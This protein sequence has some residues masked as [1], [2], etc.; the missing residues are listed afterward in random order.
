MHLNFKPFAKIGKEALTRA[1][2]SR[3]EAVEKREVLYNKN[4]I[5]LNNRF[6]SYCAKCPFSKA[7]NEKCW[8]I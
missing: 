5:D 7:H 6:S 3:V 4:L 8:N 2:M 1:L